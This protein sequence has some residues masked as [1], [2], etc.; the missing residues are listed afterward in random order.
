MNTKN[1]FWAFVAL[2][3][4]A[5]LLYTFTGTEDPEYY[6]STIEAERERQWKFLKY[7]IDSPLK[8]EQ[9]EDLD[10]LDFYPID[11]DYKIRAR[12]EPVADR[13]ILEIPMTDGSVERYIRHSFANFELQ[14]QQVKLLLLQAEDET[15]L[16][17]FFLAFAD[18][19]SGEETYGG[20]RYINV[21]QDGQSSLTIDFNLAYNPYCAYNPDYACPIPPRENI[22]E[23]PIRAGEKN[24][25]K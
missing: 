4:A 23:I 19:T 2:V 10:S 6:R 25:D 5:S 1:L 8:E 24:Y 15:D 21:R 18:K 13:R 7:N 14:G 12:L 9:K 3:I 11:P 20:G 16:R 17:N 22:L